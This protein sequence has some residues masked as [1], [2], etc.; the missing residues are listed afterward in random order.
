MYNREWGNT[1]PITEA[2]GNKY[3]FYC[4]PCKRNITCH[5]MCLGDPKQHYR[6]QH[7]KIMEKSF[8]NTHK[9]DSFFTNIA[10]DVNDSVIRAEIMQANFI[11]Q[12]NLSFLTADHLAPIYSKMFPGSKIA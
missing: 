6:T 8:K 2:N 11:V 1:Y 4:I 7:H 5:Y 12:H 9:E 3:A 10:S